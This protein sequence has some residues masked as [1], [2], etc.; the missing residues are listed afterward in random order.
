MR[1]EEVSSPFE[2]LV[3]AMS[4]LSECSD[5]FQ[6][7][8]H[9]NGNTRHRI[10]K[11]IVST[12]GMVDDVFATASCSSLQSRELIN[13]HFVVKEFDFSAAQSRKEFDVELPLGLLCF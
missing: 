6:R 8:C 7:S 1:F 3:H 9:H 10:G 11:V 5:P 12:R 4:F 13:Q 2:N